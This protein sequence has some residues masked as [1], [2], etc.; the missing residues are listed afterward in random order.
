ME[1]LFCGIPAKATSDKTSDPNKNIKNL[2]IKKEGFIPPILDRLSIV[3][4]IAL[5][6]ISF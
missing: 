4:N 6:A 2:L 5:K 3:F 1:F